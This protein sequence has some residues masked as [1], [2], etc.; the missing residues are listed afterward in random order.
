MPGDVRF[1]GVRRLLEKAG[2]RLARIS[3]SHHIFTRGG[4]APLSI[5]VHKNKVKPIYVEQ[6]RKKIEEDHDPAS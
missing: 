3:G 2:W 1:T 6:I 5:P 4:C